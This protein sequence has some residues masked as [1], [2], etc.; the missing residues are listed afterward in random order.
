MPSYGEEQKTAG[1]K[2]KTPD[3]LK[4]VEKRSMKSKDSTI[5]TAMT[6]DNIG[7]KGNANLLA[8]RG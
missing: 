3:R 6:I 1:V 2:L 5:Q 4:R 8:N 7:Y